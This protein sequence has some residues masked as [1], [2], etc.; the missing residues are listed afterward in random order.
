LTQKT[1]AEALDFVKK[2]DQARR[3]YVTSYF[4]ADPDDPLLYDLTVNL[5]RFSVEDAAHVIGQGFLTW[6]KHMERAPQR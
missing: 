4:K 1:Q 6:A 5:G 2:E 3:R